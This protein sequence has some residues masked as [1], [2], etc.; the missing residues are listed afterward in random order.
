LI[1]MLQI[2]L[3]RPDIGG[4]V[5]ESHPAPAPCCFP[6]PYRATCATNS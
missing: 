2:V 3:V 5:I 6:W 1:A 4:R